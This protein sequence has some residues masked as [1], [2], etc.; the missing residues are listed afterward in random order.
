MK[1]ISKT[2]SPKVSDLFYTRANSKQDSTEISCE[3]C[4]ANGPNCDCADTG[5]GSDSCVCEDS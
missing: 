5:T 3:S 2:D 4:D 1:E